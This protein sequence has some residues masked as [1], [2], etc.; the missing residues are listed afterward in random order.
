MK[1]VIVSVFSVFFSIGMFS[2]T[3]TNNLPSTAQDFMKKNF[4]EVSVDK[5]EEN[6]NWQID[7][8]VQNR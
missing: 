4:S 1:K 3:N 7:K 8:G 5:V 2:Q 6:S